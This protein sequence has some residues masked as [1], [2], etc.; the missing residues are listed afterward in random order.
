MGVLMSKNAEFFDF[1]ISTGSNETSNKK[2]EICNLRPL[3]LK[4]L[5]DWIDSK[6][7]DIKLKEHLKKSASKYPQQALPIW[8]KNY[9]KHLGNAQISLRNQSI[10]TMDSNLGENNEQENKIPY[11][12]EFDAGWESFGKD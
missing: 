12:E 2:R 10:P 7:I 9:Q 1:K 8:Q 6:N 3:T 5:L 11:N 4:V